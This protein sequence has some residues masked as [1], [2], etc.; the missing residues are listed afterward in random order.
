MAV[1]TTG[2]PAAVLSILVTANARPAQG[3]IAALDRQMS[4]SAMASK[5]WATALKFGA[6]GI[7]A[8]LVGSVKAAS[9]YE[10]AFAN[11]RKTVK[12]SPKDFEKLS[13]QIRDLSTHIPIAAKDLANLAGEAG[14][15]GI[16]GEQLKAF[17]KIVG[18]LGTATDDLTSMEGGKTL[19]RLGTITGQQTIGAYQ[20]MASVIVDLGNKGSS[21]EGEIA[22]MSLRIARSAHQVG[23]QS[24]EILG[25]AASL[26]NVGIRAEMGGSAISRVML[27]MQAATQ[28]GGKELEHFADVANMTSSEFK[29]SFDRDVT[30]TIT[31]FVKGLDKSKEAVSLQLE[32]LGTAAHTSLN[33]IRVRDTLLGLADNTDEFTRS[34]QTANHEWEQNNALTREFQK[35]NNTF[36]MQLELLKNKIVNVGIGIGEELLPQLTKIV[37]ILA[38]PD[39]TIGEKIS[40][41]IS[42]IGD[43]IRKWLPVALKAGVELGGQVMKGILDAFLHASIIGKAAIATALMRVVG[44]PG[45]LRTAGV[46]MGLPIGEGMM[47]SWLASMRTS[48]MATQF[49]TVLQR[50]F[51]G[52]AMIDAATGLFV[53]PKALSPLAWRIGKTLSWLM[54]NVI[55]KAIPIAFAAIGL[56]TILKDVFTG[57]PLEKI[58]LE[59]GT[60]IVGGIVGFMVGGP[61]GAALGAGLGSIFGHQLD[62]AFVKPFEANLNALGNTLARQAVKSHKS[63]EKARKDLKNSNKGVKEARAK[64]KR[65]TDALT[66]AENRLDNARKQFGPGSKQV[67]D[68]EG[69]VIRI[70]RKSAQASKELRDQEKLRGD[71]A[72]WYREESRRDDRAPTGEPDDAATAVSEALRHLPRNDARSGCHPEREAHRLREPDRQDARGHQGAEDLAA[73]LRRRR[74]GD[75]SRV[76]AQAEID[77]QAIGPRQADQPAARQ[78]E[79]DDAN[80][81]HV[82]AAGRDHEAEHRRRGKAAA[83]SEGRRPRLRSDQ[84]DVDGGSPRAIQDPAAAD[85]GCPRR[86]R[87]AHRR[88][89]Q[90]ERRPR[91]EHEEE[92]RQDRRLD[93]RT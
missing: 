68:A 65:W 63:V 79:Q 75:W 39:L 18:E 11:V 12:G 93:G 35:R 85:Q 31:E 47:A 73:D 81:D 8:A 89:G 6:V 40:A 3:T 92:H 30:G 82:R 54:A 84:R 14:A 5:R 16:K 38:D 28:V 34:M 88:G 22:S 44:G 76:R 42:N 2:R 41:F 55:T 77:C 13:T 50:G 7:T 51:V 74:Q 36:Q 37:K 90:E 43:M 87:Q 78:P 83:E 60:A 21:T 4:Y 19:A 62:I 59:V 67:V 72:K 27:A 58:G 1:S 86:H 26:S 70:K 20:R 23:L 33:E 25:F 15:L 46:A 61:W 69:E 32:G 56:Y 52:G 91:R 80:A 57:V 9:D 66:Q 29:D 49:M 64:E 10:Q 24:D 17:T 45:A 71:A 48:L 53:S